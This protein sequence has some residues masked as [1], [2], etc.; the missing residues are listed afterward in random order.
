M[1]CLGEIVSANMYALCVEMV[2]FP[3]AESQKNGPRPLV[4]V[5]I[6]GEILG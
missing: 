2:Q 4:L 5:K 1:G 6:L 3:S